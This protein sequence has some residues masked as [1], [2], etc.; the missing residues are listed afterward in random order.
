MKEK[1]HYVKLCKH[2]MKHMYKHQKHMTGI[3]ED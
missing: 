3:E 2:N 1:K